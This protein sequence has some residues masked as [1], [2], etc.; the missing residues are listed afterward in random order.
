MMAGS[1]Q[2]QQRANLGDAEGELAR[3]AH[4]CQMPHRLPVIV[5]MSTLGSPGPRN[6]ANALVLAHGFRIDPR[7][8]GQ[9][10]DGETSHFCAPC[11]LE[12]VPTPSA[13]VPEARLKRDE[14]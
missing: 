13:R 3:A 14:I 6:Q 12:P 5:P 7:R 1:R 10:P 9:L 2:G 4:E 8:F 11:A